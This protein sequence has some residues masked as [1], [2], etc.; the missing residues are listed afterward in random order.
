[1]EAKSLSEK[2]SG[3]PHPD[4]RKGWEA[5]QTDRIV[6]HMVDKRLY[7][8]KVIFEDILPIE[9]LGKEVETKV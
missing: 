1:M 4:D 9:L 5:I 6:I 2:L 8:I 3:I 7:W